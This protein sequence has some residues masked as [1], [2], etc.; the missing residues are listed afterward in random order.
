MLAIS[1]IDDLSR[2]DLA[3]R[4]IMFSRETLEPY[5]S[6]RSIHSLLAHLVTTPLLFNLTTQIVH[7]GRWDR[8]LSI[9]LP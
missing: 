6:Q 9:D 2:V 4:D 8:V 7:V 1:G 3:S 5:Q